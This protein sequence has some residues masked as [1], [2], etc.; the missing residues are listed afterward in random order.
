MYPVEI[1]TEPPQSEHCEH[2]LS[3][4]RHLVDQSA[5]LSAHHVAQPDSFVMVDAS[6]Q[7]VQPEH[8]FA[9]QSHL[10][11]DDVRRGRDTHAW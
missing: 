7:S 10:W 4:H 1:W 3:G 6:R 8:S 9:S 5:P 2:L 11:S